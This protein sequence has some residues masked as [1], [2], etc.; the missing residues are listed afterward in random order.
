[1]TVSRRQYMQAEEAGAS[2]RRA[3]KPITACPDFGSGR[4]AA[5]LAEAWHMGWKRVDRERA[6]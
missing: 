4:D 3:G 1:M 2:A 6:R 5:T